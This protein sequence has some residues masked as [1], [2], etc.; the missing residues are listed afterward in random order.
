[1]RAYHDNRTVK[2]AKEKQIIVEPL[3]FG[4]VAM[5]I[6]MED[7]YSSTEVFV[8]LKKTQAIKLIKMLKEIVQYER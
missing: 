7:D 6:E 5:T 2:L 1:M 4:K 8:S 3:Q